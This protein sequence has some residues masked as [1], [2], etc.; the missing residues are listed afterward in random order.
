[1]STQYLFPNLNCGSLLHTKYWCEMVHPTPL[2]RQVSLLAKTLNL[3]AFEKGWVWLAGGGAGDTGLITARGMHAMQNA[4]VILYDALINK[5]LL[6]LAR[7]GAEL[8]FAGKR[9]GVKSC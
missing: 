2:L 4:D 6:A 7:P 8:V 1:M 5:T 3:P 9:A